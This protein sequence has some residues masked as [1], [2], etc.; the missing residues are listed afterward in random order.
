[1]VP[2]SK[3]CKH[4]CHLCNKQ[5]KVRSASLPAAAIQKSINHSKNNNLQNISAVHGVFFQFHLLCKLS[6]MR[7]LLLK[8]R[9]N[10]TQDNSHTTKLISEGHGGD[11]V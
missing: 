1:M 7:K 9:G 11:V 4:E 5:R 2:G 6:Y 10:E 8:N 3:H